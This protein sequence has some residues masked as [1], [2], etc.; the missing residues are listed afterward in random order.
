MHKARVTVTVRPE[1][2]ALAE[3][4]VAAGRASSLSAWVDQAMK[5]KPGVRI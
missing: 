5:E 4:E 2:L 3:D 1:V